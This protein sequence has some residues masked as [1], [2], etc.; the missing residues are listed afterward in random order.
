MPENIKVKTCSPSGDLISFM[1]GFNK[2]S[3]IH[4]KKILVYQQLNVVGASYEGAIHPYSN[5]DGE[6]VLFNEYT[7]KMMA[8]LIKSQPYIEDYLPYE[9]QNI[10]FDMDKIRQE[11]FTGQP[12]GALNR[13]FF[14]AFPE[15]ANDLSK[16]WLFI[17]GGM[18]RKIIIN[19]TQRHRNPYINYFFLKDFQD[20][21]VFAG[22]KEEHELFEKQ[23][24]LSLDY[25]AVNDFLELSQAIAGCRFFMGCQSFC[26]QLAEALKV[27]RILEIFPLLPNV[28]PVGESAF[29]AYH[30]SAIEYYFKKLYHERA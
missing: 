23:F 8:P 15:M 29:D 2:L 20:H 18:H 22:L 4:D 12:K 16:P 10:D 7:F 13:W 9:G 27:P 24:N 25:L 5:K 21:I 26:F 17:N 14:Y 28:I 3:C 1:S 11:I 30:Q 6:P 19:F